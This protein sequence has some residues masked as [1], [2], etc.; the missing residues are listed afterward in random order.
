[1]TLQQI[2]NLAQ[3]GR[4]QFYKKC[5]TFYDTQ[6][7]EEY[8]ENIRDYIFMYNHYEEGKV[9]YTIADANE[10]VK[11]KATVI[12]Q[13]FKDKEPVGYGVIEVEYCCG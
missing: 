11:M 7:L 4:K 1:M 5:K 9:S 12:K 3:D 13:L 6:T 8:T 10:L 2:E